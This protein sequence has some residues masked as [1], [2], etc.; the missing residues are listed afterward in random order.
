MERDGIA[1]EKQWDASLYD[2]KHSFVWKYGEE[3]IEL[4]APRAGER[5]LD[6]GCGT[7]HLT[8][9][10]AA[11]GAEV[12]GIDISRDMVGQ[13]RALYPDLRFELGDAAS[14]HFDE[15]FDGVFSN[16]ALHWVEEQDRVTECIRK[17]LKP[18]GRFVAEF[19]GKRNTQAIKDALYHAV[20]AAGF[21]ITEEVKF[22]FF[23]SIG[24][25]A[26]LLEEHGLTVKY[27]RYFERPTALEGGE[28]GMRDWLEMFANNVLDSVPEEKRGEVIR[29]AEKRLQPELYRE[30]RWFA[31]YRRIRVVATK[32]RPG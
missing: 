32:D 26:T 3:V 25:Y 7:G 14:F 1:P 18:G 28:S 9:K 2:D 8:N 29:L 5:I 24:E 31:D 30:G 23:P 19:G 20:A 10:I 6:L 12:V 15:P 4:L 13:A 27:A 11:S 16:A 21:S 22:R 17:A